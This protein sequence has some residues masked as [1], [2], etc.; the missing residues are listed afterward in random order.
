MSL[1]TSSPY[2]CNKR[3]ISYNSLDSPH[4]AGKHHHTEKTGNYDNISVNDV[5]DGGSSGSNSI[6]VIHNSKADTSSVKHISTLI[7]PPLK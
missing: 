3:Y 2:Q 7:S 5:D 1:S 4:L 6:G